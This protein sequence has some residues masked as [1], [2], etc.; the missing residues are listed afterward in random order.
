MRAVVG[1]DRRG[2][3]DDALGGASFELSGDALKAAVAVALRPA[4][5]AG[6]KQAF[7]DSFAQ[8]RM[9]SFADAIVDE[10]EQARIRNVARVLSAI[11]AGAE[12]PQP[13][14]RRRIGLINTS[15]TRE[16][17]MDWSCR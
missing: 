17:D 13:R 4:F 15:R 2:A 7:D 10:L 8:P 9:G 6:R 12:A 11:R 16:L 5:D 1:D 14:P 3:L